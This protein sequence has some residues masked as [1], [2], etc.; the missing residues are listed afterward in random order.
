MDESELEA[1]LARRLHQRFDH[2]HAS[3]DLRQRV[4]SSFQGD[5]PVSSRRAIRGNLARLP[6]QLLAAAAVV[7]ILVVAIVALA[8]RQASVAS[9]GKSTAPTVSPPAASS[10]SA[11]PTG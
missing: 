6:R 2:A 3:A 7:V 5:L 4:V 8:G 11:S 10:A 9:P 1:R